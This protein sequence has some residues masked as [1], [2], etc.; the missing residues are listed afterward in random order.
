MPEQEQKWPNLIYI[1]RHGESAGNVARR[2]AYEAGQAVIDLAHRDMD[3]PLSDLGK[4]QAEAVGRW[5]RELPEEEKPS[6]VLS[7]PYTRACQT[8]ELL[9]EATQLDP[10]EVSWIADERLREKEFGIL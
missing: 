1:V 5:F 10:D 4:S 8:T 3:V 2:L 6:V 9:L 7:S